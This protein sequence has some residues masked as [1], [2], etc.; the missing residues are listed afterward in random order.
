[1]DAGHLE[2][3]VFRR[4]VDRRLW[5][6]MGMLALVALGA[7]CVALALAV[8]PLPVIAF[9]T[10]GRPIVFQDTRTP[11]LAMDELRVKAFVRDFLGCLR[12]VGFE[13]H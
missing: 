12:R 11:A 2:L 4:S 8:R 1:M 7:L 10:T 13:S 5:L 3:D 9:D 6:G